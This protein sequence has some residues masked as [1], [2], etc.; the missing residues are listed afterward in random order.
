MM[1]KFKLGDL[2]ARVR[3]NLTQ[4][5]W[6]NKQVI[7]IFVNIHRPQTEGN[8]CD[9]QGI[10]EKICH[11]CRQNWHMRYNDKRDKLLTAI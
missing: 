9:K 10:A 2:C 1:P 11:C 7:H 3:C 6:K 4:M 8:F 5:T